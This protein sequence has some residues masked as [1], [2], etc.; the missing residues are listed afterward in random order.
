MDCM[1]VQE[2]LP[3]Y[4]DRDLNEAQLK[5]IDEHLKTCGQCRK[6]Y[7]G[8]ASAWDVMD[9]WEDTAPPERLRK[10]ILGNMPRK[11]KARWLR[12]ALPVAAGFL[13]VIGV[14]L[15]YAGFETGKTGDM[16]ERA[17]VQQSDEHAKIN[18]DEIVANLEILEEEE[19]YDA[20]DEMVK[21]D[22]LPLMDEPEGGEKDR[23]RS[24]LDLAVA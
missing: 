8:L 15:Y 18:E 20:L 10:R 3:L 21:I 7:A 22:Y 12:V 17:T 9:A 11:G 5:D 4:Q 23:E 19:F 6:D 16:K 13:M 2:K 24:S 1:E 14:A